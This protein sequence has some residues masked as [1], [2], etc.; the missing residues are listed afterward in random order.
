MY[1]LNIQSKIQRSIIGWF[2]LL[3]VIAVCY[4]SEIFESLL[5]RLILAGIFWLLVVGYFLFRHY[6]KKT[7]NDDVIEQE[8][9]E[10][11]ERIENEEELTAKRNFENMI[12]MIIVAIGMIVTAFILKVLK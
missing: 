3:A 4:F 12:F 10:Y 1:R 11:E 8:G 7:L 9:I 2:F 6:V 5:I